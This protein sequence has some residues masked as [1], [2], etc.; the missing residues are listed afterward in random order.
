MGLLSAL[1][2]RRKIKR[3]LVCLEFFQN[4]NFY[5]L[6]QAR[7]RAS[8]GEAYVLG[9]TA[10][11]QLWVMHNYKSQE[12]SSG[13]CYINSITIFLGKVVFDPKRSWLHAKSMQAHITIFFIFGFHLP[14]KLRIVRA[15]YT[16]LPSLISC[17]VF[18]K[19]LLLRIW[20]SH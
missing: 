18:A 19:I 6:F 8:D 15:A 4:A 17:G 7:P 2:Q 5:C 9:P 16:I 3:K 20:S 10:I 13:Q 12:C 14:V 11:N 1:V